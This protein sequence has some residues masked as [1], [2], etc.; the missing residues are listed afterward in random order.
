MLPQVH[1]NIQRIK[2]IIELAKLLPQEPEILSNWAK[3][4][5]VLASGLIETSIRDILIHYSTIKSNPEVGSFVNS[6]LKG[7]TNLNFEKIKQLLYNFNNRWGNDFETIFSA[8]HKD[9]IDS[10]IA[11]RHEIAHGRNV[12]ITLVRVTEY[13]N[14]VV[15]VIQWIDDKVLR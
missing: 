4:V 3:Y 2:A 5:C 14:R 11:N 1:S 8:E 12:G 13:F 15:S 7:V 6:R 10:I 9:A